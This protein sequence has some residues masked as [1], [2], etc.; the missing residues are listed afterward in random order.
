LGLGSVFGIIGGGF[1]ADRYLR[2]GHLN[3]RVYVV[4]LGSIA[5]TAVLMPAFASTSL[6]VASPL[7]FFGGALLTLPVAPTEALF[8]D[9]VVAQLRGRAATIRSIVRGLSY[10][11]PAIIG[12]LSAQFISGGASRAD[13]LRYAIVCLC[14]IYAIGG[15]IML[16]AARTYPADVAFVVAESRRCSPAHTADPAHPADP[17]PDRAE[18]T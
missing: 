13:G 7:M 6:A 16:L 12:L 10:G 18:D 5:A 8:S 14:P 3:A 17:A 11:G 15:V 4:A 2:R 1:I 9:V